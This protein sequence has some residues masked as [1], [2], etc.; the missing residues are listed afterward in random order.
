M[1]RKAQGCKS[2]LNSFSDIG[3]YRPFAVAKLVMGMV[4]RQY[5][6]SVNI[7]IGQG[8]V[9]RQNFP[10]FC[11]IDLLTMVSALRL[12]YIFPYEVLSL[13]Y[14]GTLP[15]FYTS[16]RAISFRSPLEQGDGLCRSGKH[17]DSCRH[18]DALPGN[19]VHQIFNPEK[20][21]RLTLGHRVLTAIVNGRECR[22]YDF[23]LEDDWSMGPGKPK[24][25]V[26]EGMVF[27]DLES[28]MPLRISSSMVE[29][30]WR[31]N[32]IR[33]TTSPSLV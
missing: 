2:F 26:E 3:F 5:H 20:A 21:D 33:S 19:Y 4:V 17:R 15:F 7:S 11:K 12:N 6:G 16:I 30:P 14:I 25:V 32:T 10:V 31:Y 9:E 24:P 18:V 23:R 8:K 22:I 27:I 28:G 1:G 29:E 13:T